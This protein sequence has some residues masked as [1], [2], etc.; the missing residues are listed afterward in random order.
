MTGLF[1][2][3]CKKGGFTPVGYT[4]ALFLL[5]RVIVKCANTSGFTLLKCGRCALYKDSFIYS[6]ENEKL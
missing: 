5:H 1:C 6:A 3:V 4:P 2:I